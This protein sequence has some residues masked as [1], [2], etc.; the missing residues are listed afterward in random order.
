MKLTYDP[1]DEGVFATWEPAI[2]NDGEQQVETVSDMSRFSTVLV[3]M[4]PQ[5]SQPQP[6]VLKEAWTRSREE[7]NRERFKRAGV[8]VHQLV[9]DIV[10]EVGEDDP[11]RDR[12]LRWA[13]TSVHQCASSLSLTEGPDGERFTA[14]CAR[15]LPTVV[16]TGTTRRAAVADLGPR[17]AEAM[18]EALRAQIAD[19]PTADP[20]NEVD[21]GD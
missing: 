17:L 8:P 12:I 11:W 16:G 4:T 1:D 7:R 9:N 3:A 6:E 5:G 2:W 20:A 14:S 21:Q 13:R 18:R 10:N 19:R 15:V